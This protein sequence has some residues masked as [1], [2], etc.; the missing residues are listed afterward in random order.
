VRRAAALLLLLL[1][2]PSAHARPAGH[3]W[4]VTN[5]G[6]RPAPLPA[7]DVLLSS[8]PLEGG[9]LP[10]ATTAWLREPAA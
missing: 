2:V 4:R 5:F 1:V 7:G 8:A 10:G 9:A 6:D 3:E